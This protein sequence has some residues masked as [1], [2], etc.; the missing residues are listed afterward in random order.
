MA[1]LTPENPGF[2]V[3]PQ[4]IISLDFAFPSMLLCVGN[5]L[6]LLICLLIW[7]TNILFGH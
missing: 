2:Y 1:K 7:K 5:W 3:P 6:E 4:A